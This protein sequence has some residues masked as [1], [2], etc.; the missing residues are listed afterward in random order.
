M[1]SLHMNM[2]KVTDL[3]MGKMCALGFKFHHEMSQEIQEYQNKVM[4]LC[5]IY[6]SPQCINGNSMASVYWLK[7]IILICL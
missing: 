3:Y 1:Q 6:I 7:V 2:M 5:I 4:I